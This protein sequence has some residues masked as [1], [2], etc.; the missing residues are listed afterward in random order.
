MSKVKAW[1]AVVLM[2]AVWAG[3]GAAGQAPAQAAPAQDVTQF[4]WLNTNLPAEQR[5]EELVEHMTL[6]EKASQLV[7]SA[8]DSQPARAGL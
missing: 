8:R 2:A 6:Q 3:A 5:A 1:G 4:P 7:N